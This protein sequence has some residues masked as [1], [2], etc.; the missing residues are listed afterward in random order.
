M[1][2]TLTAEFILT[3]I[4]SEETQVLHHI[5]VSFHSILPLYFHREKRLS[6]RHPI[7][8]AQI[9]PFDK[10]RS[11]S[12]LQREI[13]VNRALMEAFGLSRKP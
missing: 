13:E 6:M 12:A 7:E 11:N 4:K 8:L 3:L 9:C 5:D 2:S 10:S 1:V